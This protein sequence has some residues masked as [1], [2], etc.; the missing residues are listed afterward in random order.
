MYSLM[1]ETN[2]YS[3]GIWGPVTA[4]LDW[5]EANYQFSRY[6]AEIT[7]T[8]SNLVPISLAFF[9]AKKVLDH[10][11]PCKNWA[12]LGQLGFALVGIGS[13][14][15]HA[16]LQYTA[17]LADELP[18]IYVA[19][20]SCFSLFD[21]EPGYDFSNPYTRNLLKVLI[22]FD[23]L[24]TWTYYLWR[25]PIYHQVVFAALMLTTG[26]RVTYLTRIS[27]VHSARVPEK[28]RESIF[29]LFW[30]GGG[31]FI[32]G[33]AIWN[34][35]NVF[36]GPI[37]YAKYMVGWPTAFLLEGHSW[38]H[39]LTGVGTYLMI[40]GVTYLGLCVKGDHSCYTIDKT[41]G[42]PY[43]AR[44]ERVFEKRSS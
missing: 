26:S 27:P 37:T 30:L 18:M 28:T 20:F 41:S 42:I 32:L 7:N 3:D 6:I 35:D 12:L 9:G 14:A 36:C 34:V 11:L 33:F 44:V 23:I 29:Q 15:F 13:F 25:N 5:C 1:N 16:T 21:T 4:T 31:L 19:A 2:A 39:I 24:F 10:D 8:L 40:Q 38:W 17:Q 22:A 43:V